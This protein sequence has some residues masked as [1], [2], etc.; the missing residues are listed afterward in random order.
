METVY[1]IL[2][3]ELFDSKI[4]VKLVLD[5]DEDF[6]AKFEIP[7]TDPTKYPFK[8]G[9]Y[10]H[11]VKDNMWEV[12]FSRL[13][14]IRG[15]SIDLLGDMDTKETL[16]TFSAVKKSTFFWLKS[17][18]PSKFMFSAK[19]SEKSRVKLYDKFAKIIAK[20]AG[21]KIEKSHSAFGEDVYT[22]TKKGKK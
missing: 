15:S 8:F 6:E 10:A 16:A 13:G 19:T 9:F 2:M 12:S 20:K 4:P 11:V 14:G 22:F 17:N 7:A 1:Q 5:K 21:Y 3:T 18:K